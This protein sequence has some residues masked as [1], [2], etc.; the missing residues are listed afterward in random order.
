MCRTVQALSRNS[1]R[2]SA[3][4][5][6]YAATLL[7]GQLMRAHSFMPSGSHFLHKKIQV[8]QRFLPGCPSDSG[9]QL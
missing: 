6:L 2:K 5:L 3:A 8:C 9:R 4:Y 1:L 7:T